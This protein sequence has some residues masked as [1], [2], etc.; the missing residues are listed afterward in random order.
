MLAQL[1]QGFYNLE[2]ARLPEI[3]L[4][5]NEGVARACEPRHILA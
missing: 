2:S 4:T 3:N 5:V 1:K